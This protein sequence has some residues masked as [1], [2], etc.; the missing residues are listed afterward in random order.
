MKKKRGIGAK[1][2]VLHGNIG[3]G[4]FNAVQYKHGNPSGCIFLNISLAHSEKTCNASGGSCVNYLCKSLHKC[5]AYFTDLVYNN[6]WK[7]KT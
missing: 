3:D 4:S 6:T 1:R 5:F 2:A 7:N